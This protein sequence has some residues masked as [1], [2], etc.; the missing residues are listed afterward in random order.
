VIA[1][2]VRG[3]DSKELSIEAEG[4]S[5][6]KEE[7][8]TVTSVVI[9][10]D[11]RENGSK[12][13]ITLFA[14]SEDGISTAGETSIGGNGISSTGV[15]TSGMGMK[16]FTRAGAGGEGREGGGTCV[17]IARCAAF[18]TLS[19]DGFFTAFVN[20]SIK[21]LFKL[22]LCILFNLIST[23]EKKVNVL[24]VHKSTLILNIATKDFR[25]SA[26]FG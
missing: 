20:Q 2:S 7:F 6:S 18:A 17:G 9:S 13:R 8:E 15:A 4:I 10:A 23:F 11:A 19:L 5:K 26:I 24:I 22:I 16:S 12:F 25:K 1:L 21:P 14:I 3:M